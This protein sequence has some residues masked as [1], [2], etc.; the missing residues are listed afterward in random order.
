M[1]LESGL[2][3][4][5]PH[6]LV[7]SR[8][9]KASVKVILIHCLVRYQTE[10]DN[11]EPWTFSV[12]GIAAETGLSERTVSRKVGPL[13]KQ[14]VLKFY[15]RM[16]DGEREYD[17]FTFSPEGLVALIRITGK[18]SLVVR[19]APN[20]FDAPAKITADKTA[21]NLSD[22]LSDKTPPRREDRRREEAKREDDNNQGLLPFFS[23][24][25]SDAEGGF[26]VGMPSTTVAHPSDSTTIQ[27]ACGNSNA[28]GKKEADSL[29]ASV[30]APII[31]GSVS[32]N[33]NTGARKNGTGHSDT[34]ANRPA[35][36]KS[37]GLTDAE[38]DDLSRQYGFTKDQLKRMENG[39][40]VE[41]VCGRRETKAR[42]GFDS[43]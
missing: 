27:H 16:S 26:C 5:V 32:G 41:V 8:R 39:A 17:V 12:A 33:T 31:Q 11:G 25:S 20:G 28:G 38:L 22:N 15:G 19:P 13:R 14:G 43:L 36:T 9:L 35:G 42:N 34:S 29:L 7:A 1:K 10:K 6:E 37:M 3:A 30:S 2:F 21:D 18:A 23:G 4:E 40:L 24:A